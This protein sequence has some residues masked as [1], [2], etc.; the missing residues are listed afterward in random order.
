MRTFA[1]FFG[2]SGGFVMIVIAARFG[3]K[4]SDNDFDGYIWAFTYG[5]VTLGGLFGHSLALRVWRH[6]QRSAA[7][8]WSYP[9]L[10]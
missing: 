5:S 9:P 6:N 8:L 4:T 10:R 3:F 7:L 2:L 1:R